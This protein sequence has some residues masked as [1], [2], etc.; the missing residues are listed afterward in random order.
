MTDIFKRKLY[1]TATLIFILSISLFA[2]EKDAPAPTPDTSLWAGTLVQDEPIL[3]LLDETGTPLPVSLIYP[4][5]EIISVMNHAQTVTYTPEV[6]Y[7]LTDGQLQILPGGALARE[8]GLPADQYHIDIYTPGSTMPCIDGGGTIRTEASPGEGG[9]TTW[10]AVVT[11]RHSGEEMLAA[12]AAQGDRLPLTHQKLEA[13]EAVSIVLLGDSIAA[14][15]SASGFADTARAPGLAPWFDQVGDT[16]AARFP[17]AAI[18]L[19]NLAVRGKKAAWGGEPD[20]IAAVCAYTPD[21]L[22]LAFG[23][24][25]GTAGGADADTFARHITTIIDAVRAQCPAV[26]VVLVSPML[27]NPAVTGMLT[28]QQDYSAALAEVTASNAGTALADMTAL[29]TALLERKAY[30]D[31]SANNLNHP[32]DFLHT[33]YAQLLLR[34]L[35]MP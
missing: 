33:L 12:P 5:T 25:D 24:N 7:C 30:G 23:M 16:L 32:N 22:I 11:Y 3:I 2:C 29:H 1:T 10:Q 20:Q 8:L 26:E 13:G 15:W 35:E 9:L 18:S 28:Y 19:Y 14:G 17:D 27:P 31:L 6:D 4:P 34:T 21:L